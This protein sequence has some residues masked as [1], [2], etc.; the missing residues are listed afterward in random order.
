MVISALKSPL[1]PFIKG[2]NFLE[3]FQKHPLFVKGG[4][5]GTIS[6]ATNSSSP[7][8]K[9]GPRGILLRL[10]L[11]KITAAYLLHEQNLIIPPAYLVGLVTTERYLAN[12][13]ARQ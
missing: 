3:S 4:I 2:G 8:G 5:K 10:P 1:P 6:D 7:F 12:I 9:G 13:A 11:P